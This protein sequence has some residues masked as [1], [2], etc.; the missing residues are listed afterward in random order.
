MDTRPWERPEIAQRFK[1]LRRKALLTQKQLGEII[2]ICRQSICE[3]E[4]GQV[5]PHST[6]W[7]RFCD[8]ETKHNQPR[9][10]I[11]THWD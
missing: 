7:D 9:I 1:V 6:T 5:V 10:V 11:P 4:S 2:R 8:L 3:I